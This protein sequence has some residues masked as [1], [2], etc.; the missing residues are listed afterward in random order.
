[1][2]PVQK[3]LCPRRAE[4]PT[5]ARFPDMDVWDVYDGNLRCSFCGSLHPDYVL[6]MMRLGVELGPTDKNYKIYV[7]VLGT[8][9]GKFYFQHFDLEQKHKFIE[10]YNQ[11]P[12]NFT[13][14]YP[15]YFYVLPYFIA[16]E[17]RVDDH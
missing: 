7:K 2:M 6:E 11:H 9:E 13:V 14:G 12:R 17:R 5:T 4:L 15:G 8:H 3:Q 1:M 16:I 10:L